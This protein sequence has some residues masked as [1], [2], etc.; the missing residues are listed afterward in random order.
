MKKVLFALGV[1]AVAFARNMPAVC[2]DYETE[3]IK[4]GVTVLGDTSEAEQGHFDAQA[5]DANGPYDPN[6]SGPNW[7]GQG[8]P[9]PPPVIAS[10]SPAY[11]ELMSTPRNMG[12]LAPN[13]G[14][15]AASTS[16]LETSSEPFP[17]ANQVWP[18]MLYY[19][20]FLF[21]SPRAWAPP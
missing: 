12:G 9:K 5:T 3:V 14:A 19:A 17:C 16:L 7:N 10:H 4:F 6:W 20:Y 18:F 21:G 2:Q 1:C 13:P 11:K 15:A 8:N